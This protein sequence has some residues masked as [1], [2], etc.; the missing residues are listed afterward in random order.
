MKKKGSLEQ[1][2]GDSHVRDFPFSWSGVLESVEN[3]RVFS[4]GLVVGGKI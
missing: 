2:S 4:V 1:K 3:A